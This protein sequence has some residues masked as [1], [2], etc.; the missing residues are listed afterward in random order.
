M[1]G[2]RAQATQSQCSKR[3]VDGD[4]SVLADEERNSVAGSISLQGGRGE[5]PVCEERD[6]PAPLRRWILRFR[7]GRVVIELQMTDIPVHNVRETALLRG[8]TAHRLADC[9][10]RSE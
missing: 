7:H 1:A 10:G 6:R 5:N 9:E 4:E 3:W 2:S 8:V